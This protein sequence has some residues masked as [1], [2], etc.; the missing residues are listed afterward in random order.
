MAKKPERQL[1]DN[2]VPVIDCGGLTILP[3][4]KLQCGNASVLDVNERHLVRHQAHGSGNRSSAVFSNSLAYEAKQVMA[5]SPIPPPRVNAPRRII[6]V[7]EKASGWTCRS[8][9]PRHLFHWPTIRSIRNGEIRKF[10]RGRYICARQDRKQGRRAGYESSHSP[11]VRSSGADSSSIQMPRRSLR[12]RIRASAL[13][14]RVSRASKPALP[15][16]AGGPARRGARHSVRNN[17]TANCFRK[18]NEKL[19]YSAG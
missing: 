17:P 3:I 11:I 13:W 19:S 12:A 6:V 16:P 14:R 10:I 15:L 7:G 1:A 5:L 4:W 9:A 2:L 8:H 18:R